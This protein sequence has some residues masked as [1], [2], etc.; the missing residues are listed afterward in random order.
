MP[1]M[2]VAGSLR[3]KF[4]GDGGPAKVAGLSSPRCTTLIG[5]GNLYVVD[6]GNNRIRRVDAKTGIISTVAGSGKRD[7]SG[8]GGPALLAGLEYPSNSYSM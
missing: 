3:M 1:P 6:M 8:D 2:L 5:E 7:S 4:S